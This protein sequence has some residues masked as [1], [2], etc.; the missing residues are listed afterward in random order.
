M[1]R[2]LIPFF[3]LFHCLCYSQNSTTTSSISPQHQ[4][5]FLIGEWDVFSK[6]EKIA[7]NTINLLQNG[8]L[9]Q[10]N[11]VSETEFFTGTSY[12]FYNKKIKQWQQ[13]WV[14]SNGNNL[15]LNGNFKDG[16]M[17]LKSGSNC[18]MGEAQSI[19][20]ISW[21]LLANEE[22]KQVWE[23]STNEGQNWTIQ[24]EGIYKKKD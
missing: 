18:D 20:R 4:F 3:I 1:K 16:K 8:H 6:D 19:H 17:V 12:S 10:E 13:F 21:I 7:H 14:D 23:S 5:D 22:I 15:F 24:F 9:L 2:L 11:W